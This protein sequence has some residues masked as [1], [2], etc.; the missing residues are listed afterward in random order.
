MTREYGVVIER[1]RDGF[2]VGEVPSLRGCY[3]QGR[4]MD[5]LLANAREV[6]ALCFEDEPESAAGGNPLVF[7][8]DGDG[9]PQL[10]KTPHLCYN[11]V[12]VVGVAEWLRHLVVAQKTVGS[13]PTAHPIAFRKKSIIRDRLLC[14]SGDR[15]WT[16]GAGAARARIGTGGDSPACQ[17][18]VASEYG[19]LYRSHSS[20][21]SRTN[22]S[23]CRWE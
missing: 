9:L 21:C 8:P 12:T 18:D 4:T 11:P 19:R 20:R 2:Y 1:G 23:S 10:G 17:G 5:E 14:L 13:N 3:A 6:S 15:T 22:A 16:A 7:R